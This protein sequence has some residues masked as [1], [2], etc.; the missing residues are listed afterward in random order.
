VGHNEEFPHQKNVAAPIVLKTDS[1]I[2][3]SIS[4]LLRQLQHTGQLENDS[5]EG[6]FMPC[7]DGPLLEKLS[8]YL[9]KLQESAAAELITNP[10]NLQVFLEESQGRYRVR[11]RLTGRQERLLRN[12]GKIEARIR[13]NSYV[14]PS[15]ESF[16]FYQAGCGF[17]KLDPVRRDRIASLQAKPVYR[18]NDCFDQQVRKF[19][20]L[21]FFPRPG[22][23]PSPI[24]FRH[25]QLTQDIPTLSQVLGFVK[26]EYAKFPFTA[27]P[28]IFSIPG[29]THFFIPPEFEL[30]YEKDCAYTPQVFASFKISENYQLTHEDGFVPAYRLRQYPIPFTSTLPDLF[31]RNHGLDLPPGFSSLR[32]DFGL[33]LSDNKF[34]QAPAFSIISYLDNCH[35]DY[36]EASLNLVAAS[37]EIIPEILPLFEIE[38]DSEHSDK[39]QSGSKWFEKTVPHFSPELIEQSLPTPELSLSADLTLSQILPPKQA[40]FNWSDRKPHL[41]IGHRMS[42]YRNCPASPKVFSH[43][44]TDTSVATIEPGEL[45]LPKQFK[46][47]LELLQHR[48]EVGFAKIL[49]QNSAIEVSKAT[50]NPTIDHSLFFK[51]SWLE[52]PDRTPSKEGIEITRPEKFKQKFTSPIQSLKRILLSLS[53]DDGRKNSNILP[54]RLIPTFD[55]DYQSI[56]SSSAYQ[57]NQIA[58]EQAKKRHFSPSRAGMLEI[59][60]TGPAEKL[61]YSRFRSAR[62]YAPGTPSFS[63]LTEPLPEVV[64]PVFNSI[65][66]LRQKAKHHF[67]EPQ[68]TRS[69]IKI[70]TADQQLRAGISPKFSFFDPVLYVS[71]FHLQKFAL[72]FNTFPTTAHEI[73]VSE[74]HLID[75]HTQLSVSLYQSD[76]QLEP[77]EFALPKNLPIRLK[78]SESLLITGISDHLSALTII[79]VEPKIESASDKVRQANFTPSHKKTRKNVSPFSLPQAYPLFKPSFETG[80]SGDLKRFSFRIPPPSAI[81]EIYKNLIR[82]AHYLLES[83][84]PLSFSPLSIKSV[85]FLINHSFQPLKF[86]EGIYF[87]RR[88]LHSPEKIKFTGDRE[89]FKIINPKLKDLFKLAQQTSRKFTEVSSRAGT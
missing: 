54:I 7:L 75:K 58:D 14:M 23:F 45:N 40:S 35:N 88:I 12:T 59:S 70:K 77:Y 61:F 84:L 39:N 27:N 47:D 48:L 46:I 31:A 36:L 9:E 65:S 17:K 71:Q 43:S 4:R 11:L 25:S 76:Y 2:N 82:Q 32:F 69:E 86:K 42:A 38:K 1:L 74:N 29:V 66:F 56:S 60:S 67:T 28:Q 26:K 73:T 49:S 83:D 72:F 37:A 5:E 24:I 68:L 6:D 81:E 33:R 13:A 30:A 78:K 34:F 51:T 57:C 19:A 55:R 80:R 20:N 85:D 50:Q 53:D 64:A 44:A 8:P 3:L 89:P 63:E 41:E 16:S 52:R 22:R 21:N 15:P 87:V 10:A 18:F 79:D 62:P